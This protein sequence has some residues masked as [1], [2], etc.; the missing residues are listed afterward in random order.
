SAV[1]TTFNND[2]G[3]YVYEINAK[4]GK[5]QVSFE[6]TNNTYSNI[7]LSGPAVKVYEGYF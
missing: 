4:G 3:H 5:L 1:A 6:K 2:N 7:W